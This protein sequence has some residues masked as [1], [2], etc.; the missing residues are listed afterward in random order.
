MRV[1]GGAADETSVTVD[2]SATR[3][4]AVT[5]PSSAVAIG[6]AMPHSDPNATSRRIAPIP[7][8]TSSAWLAHHDT[9]AFHVSATTPPTA[10]RTSPAGTL[11]TASWSA[12]YGFG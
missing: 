12:E 6:M 2:S 1:T 5:A 8:P 3:P 9:G 10:M 4:L 11:S 7:R